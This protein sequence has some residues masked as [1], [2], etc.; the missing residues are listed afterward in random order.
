[1]VQLHECLEVSPLLRS[2]PQFTDCNHHLS[3]SDLA[4]QRNGCLPDGPRQ[5][6]VQS[7][8]AAAVRSGD[9]GSVSDHYDSDPESR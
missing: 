3:G 2:V 1:M 6:T 4:V 8:S 9:G 7:N 5:H